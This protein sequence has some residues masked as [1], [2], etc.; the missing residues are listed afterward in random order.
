MYLNGVNIIMA[1]YTIIILAV[2]SVAFL[3][4]SVI[5]MV[6]V[7]KNRNVLLLNKSFASLFTFAM[8]VLELVLCIVGFVAFVF[9]VRKV[10][11]MP[12]IAAIGYFLIF[13]VSLSSLMFM[14]AMIRNLG[15]I[16]TAHKAQMKQH[17]LFIDDISHEIRTPMN[18]VYGIVH[19]MRDDESFPQNQ[20]SNLDAMSEAISDLLGI[21]SNLIDYTK[22]QCN[23]LD[24]I[25][26]DYEARDLINTL[27]DRAYA[28]R[29]D[30][31]I[32]FSY[33]VDENL[34][35]VLNGDEVR[36]IQVVSGLLND[37]L[38]NYNAGRVSL[39]ISSR[40]LNLD[41]IILEF[42]VLNNGRRL[43]DEETALVYN[44]P[45]YVY[46]QGQNS[47]GRRLAFYIFKTVIEKMD[48]RISVSSSDKEGNRFAVMIPQKRVGNATIGCY[49]EDV[50]Y[51]ALDKF[52]APM[53]RILVVDDSIVNLFVVK[54]LL[55]RYGSDVVT[56]SSGEECLKLMASDHFDLIFMDYLM[57][58]MN[59]YETLCK[60]REMEGE[61]FKTVP[62]IELTAMTNGA[63]SKNY[64][65][66][67]FAGLLPKP[68]DVNSLER[69]LIKF[70]PADYIIHASGEQSRETRIEDR[71]WYKRLC[72]VLTGFDVMKGLE[73]SGY[74]YMSYL[75][76]LRS[77][78]DDHS[79]WPKQLKDYSESESF[80]SYASVLHKMRE[81]AESVGDMKL[82]FICS[83]HEKAALNRDADYIRNHLNT[84]LSEYEVFMFRIDTILQR[85]NEMLK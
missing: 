16:D 25:P 58:N 77:I 68:I 32:D 59:G 13:L 36:I 79:I 53:A 40:Q 34:P 29:E 70:L 42:E 50:G 49:S 26:T 1:I 35:S 83:E 15:L 84:L 37:A 31:A 39:K 81:H 66:E 56:A 54:E 41:S 38:L 43:T 2:T 24:I 52:T 46:E 74:D 11:N 78:Y 71:A 45:A 8:P 85:E 80:D 3:I 72:S 75:N 65:D 69:I 63:G 18:T 30:S 62:V 73:N 64:V 10:W 17:A 23:K 57:P 6:H 21:V 20:H 9:N 60:I 61:Y 19:I 5:S 51:S 33:T 44:D 48:G 55:G 22:I 14:R 4:I 7:Y 28:A 27:L 76:R 82:G 67:G 47:R 12:L